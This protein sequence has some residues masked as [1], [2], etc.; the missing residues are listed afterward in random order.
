M[1]SNPRHHTRRIGR[2]VMARG[3]DAVDCAFVTS[4]G[5]HILRLFKVITAADSPV[6]EHHEAFAVTV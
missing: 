1:C 2:I 4:F 3:C 6:E 5:P